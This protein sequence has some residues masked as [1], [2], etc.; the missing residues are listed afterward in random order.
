MFL[1]VQFKIQTE[2]EV[3]NSNLGREKLSHM[4]LRLFPC[5]TAIFCWQY[6][7]AEPKNTYAHNFFGTFSSWVLGTL[8]DVKH[9]W[10]SVSP[11]SVFLRYHIFQFFDLWGYFLGRA[12]FSFSAPKSIIFNINQKSLDL[13]SITLHMPKICW[14][15][16][17]L[18][19]IYLKISKFRSIGF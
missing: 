9:M 4:I 8:G 5:S 3:E 10:D 17:K 7:R 16:L 2:R 14:K 1:N 13:L 19:M 12:C 15:Y 18:Y 6:L 11:F